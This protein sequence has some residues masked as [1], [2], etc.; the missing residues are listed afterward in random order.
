MASFLDPAT[1]FTGPAATAIT[2]AVGAVFGFIGAIVKGRLDERTQQ[3]RIR[4]ESAL[5]RQEKLIAAQSMF[6]DE[7][8]KTMWDWRYSAVRVT[9]YGSLR[10]DA[11]CEAAATQ[12]NSQRWSSLSQIRSL[13]SRS[14]RLISA[15]A[16]EDILQFYRA[17]MALDDRIDEILHEG[18]VIRRQVLFGEVNYEIVTALS[19]KIDGLL[20]QVGR[21]IGLAATGT[22]SG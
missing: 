20:L 8:T 6:L 17:A 13:A 14:L 3:R 19:E 7:L 10:N 1:W 9:Y 15:S 16:H 12:Y 4:L 2:G 22:K 21:D 5:A 11:E 18:D